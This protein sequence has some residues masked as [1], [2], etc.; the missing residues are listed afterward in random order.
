MKK[1]YILYGRQPFRIDDLV[2]ER[3]IPVWHCPPPWLSEEDNIRARIELMR[4]CDA[5]MLGAPEEDIRKTMVGRIELEAAHE[6]G[7]VMLMDAGALRRWLS[8]E[9]DKKD[10]LATKLIS[11]HAGIRHKTRSVLDKLFGGD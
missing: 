5:V 8:F 1:I 7:R 6:I 10:E 2:D 3:V 9:E 11:K 4:A